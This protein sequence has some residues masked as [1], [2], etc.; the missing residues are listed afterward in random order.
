M[1]KLFYILNAF[2]RFEQKR[3]KTSNPLPS[4]QLSG[5]SVLSLYDCSTS[6]LKTLRKKEK[7][8]VTSNFSFSH[9]VFYLLG[10][11]L[12]FSSNLELS[13]ANSFSLEESNICRLGKS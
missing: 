8:L 4:R 9:G 1:V 11:F 6:L 12:P 2:N 3:V 5:L 13:S 10:E 7:L